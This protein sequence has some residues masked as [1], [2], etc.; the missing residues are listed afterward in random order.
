[1]RMASKK[2]IM[3]STGYRTGIKSISKSHIV[4]QDIHLGD[5]LYG[6]DI[7]YGSPHRLQTL[8]AVK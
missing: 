7:Q 1:M 4:Y 6:S 2:I 8:L 3:Y 5:M